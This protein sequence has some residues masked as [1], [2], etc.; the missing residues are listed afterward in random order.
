MKKV[1]ENGYKK[2]LQSNPGASKESLKRIKNI[3]LINVGIHPFF[4]TDSFEAETEAMEFLNQVKKYKPKDV[5]FRNC[6]I[7]GLIT[8]FL[9]LFI[10]ETI[11]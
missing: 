6:G 10:V 8:K 9:S 3:N 11:E 2:Y 5:S 4:S 1:Y 7:N